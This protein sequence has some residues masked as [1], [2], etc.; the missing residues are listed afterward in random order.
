METIK[1]LA[2]YQ[3]EIVDLIMGFE[4]LDEDERLEMVAYL[5]TYFTDSERERFVQ[6]SLD[7]TC[8]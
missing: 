1:R 5:D 2:A 7:P 3:D 6:Y 8:R 4:Y